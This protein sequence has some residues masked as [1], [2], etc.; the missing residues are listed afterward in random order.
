MLIKPSKSSTELSALF[1]K[2]KEYKWTYE[3]KL[4]Q[5]ISW[6]YGTQK[7]SGPMRTKEEIKQSMIDNCDIP[8]LDAIRAT[9]RQE[10][11]DEGLDSRK[12]LAALARHYGRLARQRAKAI[13]DLYADTPR[14]LAEARQ[15]GRDEG[16]EVAALSEDR[17]SAAS[18]ERIR[19]LKSLPPGAP[20][21]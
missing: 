17:W 19:A 8:D 2:A 13:N 1:E 9:A 21:A 12:R 3:A 11:R 14:I 10:G 4:E 5:K 20:D 6:V 16:L 7:M 15:E 18:A